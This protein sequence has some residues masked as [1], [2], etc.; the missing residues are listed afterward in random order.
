MN[1]KT[2]EIADLTMEI[3]INA[4]PE[5]V[6][7]ALT[8]DIGQWWPAD[9]FAGGEAGKRTYL[10]EAEPGGR[11]Y[12]QWEGGGGVLWGN[13]IAVDPTV[14]LQVLGSLF[15]NWGG[16]S[17]WFATW[18]LAASGNGT[19]VTFSES[20]I[21]KVSAGGAEEK[22]AGWEFLWACMKA[23]IEGLPE[24]AWGDL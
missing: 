7:T 19:V 21:G 8:S 15:P 9:F 1:L 14:R 23:H 10:L 3:N 5:R 17:L 13:V 2:A 16:P 24:P 18:D 11:M 22:T 20:A 6:W 4:T 12:E